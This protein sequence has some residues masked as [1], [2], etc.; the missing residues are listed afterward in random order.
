MR[1]IKIKIKQTLRHKFVYQLSETIKTTRICVNEL[2]L[3][4]HKYARWRSMQNIS[5]NILTTQSKRVNRVSHIQKLLPQTRWNYGNTNHHGH[6][7][8]LYNTS[9]LSSLRKNINIQSEFNEISFAQSN[10][11][12]NSCVG[13]IA[14]LHSYI[15]QKHGYTQDHYVYYVRTLMKIRY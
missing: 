1:N 11:R 14:Y 15:R 8:A 9:I 3:Y 10:R 4:Q 13:R 2:L 12:I 7:M 5:E 6:T